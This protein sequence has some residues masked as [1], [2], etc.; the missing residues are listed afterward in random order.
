MIHK[1]EVT[2]RLLELL[3]SQPQTR[4]HSHIFASEHLQSDEWQ[5][6][7]W[8][9]VL[10]IIVELEQVSKVWRDTNDKNN[11]YITATKNSLGLLNELKAK[12]RSE[13]EREK[14]ESTSSELDIRVK[15]STIKT[16][17]YQRYVPIASLIVS[18]WAAYYTAEYKE[19]VKDLT[20][21]LESTQ[22]STAKI[23]YQIHTIYLAIDSMRGQMKKDSS[24]KHTKR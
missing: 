16:H 23:Q 8:T 9:F 12:K 17:W 7:D 11:M 2:L 15:K 6:A 18:I 20:K 13:Q 4:I 14:R 24:L 1:E 5:D 10:A 22:D 3:H 21:S 19:K